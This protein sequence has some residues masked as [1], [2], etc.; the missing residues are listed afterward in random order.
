MIVLKMKETTKS[1]LGILVTNS[2]IAVP[3]YSN[4]SQRQVTKT[5]ALN[6]LQIIHE[7]TAAAITCGVDKK[8]VSE[9]NLLI[10]DI[11]GGNFEV[12]VTAGAMIILKIKKTVESYLGTFVTNSVIAIPAYFNNSKEYPPNHQ[13]TYH[14]C[15]HL[16][17]QQEGCQQMQPPHL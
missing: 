12:K 17:S 15:Y 4:D 6:I 2:V 3:A 13:Q 14:S 8:V 11:G 5:M 1:Y 7:P 9:C 10:L 16:W